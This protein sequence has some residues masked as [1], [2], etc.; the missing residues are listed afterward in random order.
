[1]TRQRS[2]PLNSALRCRLRSCS[3]RYQA[4]SMLSAKLRAS[5]ISLEPRY[6]FWSSKSSLSPHLSTSPEWTHSP[7]IASFE[8]FVNKN[9]LKLESM[10]VG[11]ATPAPA[12]TMHCD[13]ESIKSQK[14]SLL[15]SGAA[16][17]N[18]SPHGSE[19][20]LCCCK[21]RS[22]RLPDRSGAGTALDSWSALRIGPAKRTSFTTAWLL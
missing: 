7:A 22:P 4:L 9:A 15:Q 16:N 6:G 12:F 10:S 5:L 3:Q 2:F 21:Y 18:N 8:V 17:S 19:F 20:F 13:R 1:M 11:A 14:S